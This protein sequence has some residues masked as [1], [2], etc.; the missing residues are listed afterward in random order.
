MA[1]ASE[2]VSYVVKPNY[3]TLGPKFG[4]NM[5]AVAAAVAALPADETGDQLA[6]GRSAS[7]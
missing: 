5:P 1:S 3:R 2:L 6:S 4:K 7:R